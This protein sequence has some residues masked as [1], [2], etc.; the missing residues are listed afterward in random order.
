M[1]KPIAQGVYV[2]QHLSFGVNREELSGKVK[3]ANRTREIRP[4]GIVGGL[5]GNVGY[6]GTRNPLHKP[7]GCM[8]ETLRL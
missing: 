3:V 7:K 8:S 5:C 4:S 6:G 1:G 2:C